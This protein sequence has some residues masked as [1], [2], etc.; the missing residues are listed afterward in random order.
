MLLL[1]LQWYKW[2]S[3]AIVTARFGGPQNFLPF[4][5]PHR[6]LFFREKMESQRA[7]VLGT[8]RVPRNL[9]NTHN[10]VINSPFEITVN[11]G[12]NGLRYEGSSGIKY[13][14][15]GPGFPNVIVL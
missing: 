3:C 6:H 14:Y 13:F 2:C 7:V 11:L 5:A 12:Y 1:D 9:V 15:F 4:L 8:M 10:L